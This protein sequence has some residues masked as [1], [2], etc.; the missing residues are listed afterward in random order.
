M[1]KDDNSDAKSECQSRR[2][3][4]TSRKRGDSFKAKGGNAKGSLKG[5]LYSGR[6]QSESSKDD[7]MNLID[8]GNPEDAA[9]QHYCSLYNTAYVYR[10]KTTAIYEDNK[11]YIFEVFVVSNDSKL[12]EFNILDNLWKETLLFH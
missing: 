5:G 4:G 11:P 2:S 10:L 7:S 6:L 9:S 1:S 8:K 12:A 3:R